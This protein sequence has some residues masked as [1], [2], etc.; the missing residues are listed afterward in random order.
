MSVASTTGNFTL[1]HSHCSL[2][3]TSAR[4]LKIGR[5]CQVVAYGYNTTSAGSGG[6]IV[7][8]TG[9]PFTSWNS[10]SMVGGGTISYYH[11]FGTGFGFNIIIRN[12]SNVMYM[13]G[14][15]AE[16][17][18]SQPGTDEMAIRND[19]GSTNKYFALSATYIT[20]S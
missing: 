6:T 14:S 13:R 17:N 12:N 7:H 8:L 10:G 11:R 16:Q 15:D 9:L 3:V 20:A 1:G 19:W 5:L 18:F 2:S 4:Y